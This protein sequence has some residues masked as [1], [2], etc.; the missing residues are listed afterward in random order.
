MLTNAIDTS[1]LKSIDSC[2]ETQSVKFSASED[3]YKFLM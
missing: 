3:D 1:A 2:D